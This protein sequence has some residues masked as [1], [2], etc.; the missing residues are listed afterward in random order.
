MGF[1]EMVA[2]D[3]RKVFLNPDELAE[4]RTV[5]YDGGEPYRDIPVVIESPGAERRENSQIS[6]DHMYGL[7]TA[8]AVLYCARDDLGSK[9]PRPG[10]KI[11]ISIGTGEDFYD[12]Y[13]V[14]SAADQM[15]MLRIELEAMR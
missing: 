8:S 7:H 3:N 5:R 10:D 13:H 6:R 2:R 4:I 12:C 14:A 1:K 15:G 11:E 9:L